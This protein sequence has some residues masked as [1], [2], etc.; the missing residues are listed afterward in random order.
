MVLPEGSP[1]PATDRPTAPRVAAVGAAVVLL[2]GALVV[3]G[4]V[5]APP[6]EVAIG[7]S[8][9]TT[10]PIS[11]PTTTT[12]IDL[13]EF[14]VSD[15]T[16]GDRFGW[17][18]APG[19][20]RMWPLDLV[21]HEGQLYL[22]GSTAHPHRQS[23]SGALRAW[24]SE[25]GIKWVSLGEVAGNGYRV[26]RVV[27]TTAG[28]FALGARLED[29]APHIWSSS[30][31]DSW[32]AEELPKGGETGT[33]EFVRL[34]AVTELDGRLL[35]FGTVLGDFFGEIAK[36]LPE[37]VADHLPYG[38]SWSRGPDGYR[39]SVHG[40]L[41]I[42]GFSATLDELGISDEVATS[43]FDLSRRPEMAY[44]WSSRDGT[45]WEVEES[46]IW[47]VENFWP[48]PDGLLLASSGPRVWSSSDGLE[49]EG[50][51]T[52]SRAHI[53]EIQIREFW[54]GLLIGSGIGEHLFQSQD[55]IEWEQAGTGDLLPDQ[56]QWHLDPV[57]AGEGGVAAVA[58]AWHRV[59]TQEPSPV[60]IEKEGHTLTVDLRGG[61]MT[62]DD[63]DGLT[64]TGPLLSSDEP[65]E[66]VTVDF[67]EEQVTFHH[68]ETDEPM[69]SFGFATLERVETSA[70]S[71]ELD[72]GK[73]LLFAP[74]GEK[75]SLQDLSTV[76]G[77]DDRIA[78]MAV[79]ADRVILLTY[80]TP[81]T[82]RSPEPPN[83]TIR[84]GAI[85]SD[86]SG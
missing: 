46:D 15:I 78:D 84:V 35:V 76:M 34:S 31:G 18:N 61:I 69:V 17:I 37:E 19:V 6:E 68:P 33:G 25:N 56:L 67:I 42:T 14:S 60:I 22:F 2:L 32:V 10:E 7:V 38:L 49:W 59:A 45:D 44:R 57:A 81:Q 20:G 74:D 29:N 77:D 30:D 41:G 85:R 47:A 8:T 58:T 53:H 5:T 83:I 9:T 16:T 40:P 66:L 36:H 70:T 27:S 55:G 65:S 24:V 50:H 12:T 21:H 82:L 48:G 52:S 39:V 54:E 51:G 3:L 73:A 13:E 4:Q 23:E 80:E 75:W 1:T 72:T 43:F 63:P 62:L 79:L 86:N 64:I 28:L 71:L 26:H 11:Q